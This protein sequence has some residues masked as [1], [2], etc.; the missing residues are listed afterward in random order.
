MAWPLLHADGGVALDLAGHHV[1]AGTMSLGGL[2]QQDAGAAGAR[3]EEQDDRGHRLGPRAHQGGGHLDR[4]VF[5]RVDH[6]PGP[7]AG[8][9]ARPRPASVKMVI[10]PPMICR[11][12]MPLGVGDAAIDGQGGAPGHRGVGRSGT[13]APGWGPGGPGRRARKKESCRLPLG[14]TATDSSAVADAVLGPQ[15]AV[16]RRRRGV[17]TGQR[18][19]SATQARATATSRQLGRPSMPLP[20]RQ[21]LAHRTSDGVPRR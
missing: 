4:A 2:R 15:T 16:G 3:G 14:A 7:P 20:F 17:A 1:R 12:T 8:W 9:R 5:A 13:A 11:L 10:W 21:G 6:A 19:S 18:Q